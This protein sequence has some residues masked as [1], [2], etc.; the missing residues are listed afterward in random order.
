MIT[1]QNKSILD[2]IVN[3]IENELASVIDEN[4]IYVFK[5]GEWQPLTL[6]G[7]GLTVSLYDINANVFSQLSPLKEEDLEDSKVFLRNFLKQNCDSGNDYFALICFKQN[8]CTIFH[9]TPAYE[10]D[11]IDVLFEILEGLGE[12]K[13]IDVT[14]YFSVEIWIT[15][16]EDKGT[17]CF[18][19]F[20][21]YSGIVEVKSV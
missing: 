9:N 7:E 18:V 4:K 2:K 21:Y 3:K 13:S 19:F 6:N 1:V 8:Y 10:E 14:D 15:L 16:P 20:P 5:E 17:D 11:Y 12:I